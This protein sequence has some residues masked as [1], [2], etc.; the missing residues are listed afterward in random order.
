MTWVVLLVGVLAITPA[1]INF[2]IIAR[3]G[4][5]FYIPVAEL[6]MKGRFH[7]VIWSP[8][9]PFIIP[10]YE[11]LIF[12]VARVSGLDLE[13]SG[14]AISIVS[15]IF[16]TLG[17]YKVTEIIFKDRIVAIISV[18]FFISN[19]ELLW[20]S[21]DCLKESL[22]VCLVLWGNYFIVKGYYSVRGV[23]YTIGGILTLLAGGLVRST[24]MIFLGAWFIMW[25][26][27][28]KDGS[29]KRVLLFFSIITLTFLIYYLNQKLHWGLPIFRRSY[30]PSHLI[31]NE[32]SI[33]DYRI[34]SL[35]MIRQLFAKSYYLIGFFSLIGIYWR[36]R[37]TYTV[38]LVI[39]TLIFFAICVKTTWVFIDRYTIVLVIWLYPIAAYALV[40]SLRSLN[41]PL[42]IIAVIT[43][44]MCPLLWGEKVF[45]PPDPD[46]L[47]RKEAGLWILDRLGPDQ[48]IISN[49]DRLVFYAQG[50]YMP[51]SKYKA[52]NDTKSVLAVDTKYEEGRIIVE[53]AHS[54]GVDPDKQF[55]SISIYLPRS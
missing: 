5:N 19:R 35:N 6:L 50:T 23:K 1:L 41:K 25:I 8:L 48:V 12:I 27:H 30:D 43:M 20:R 47:A 52:G 45:T 14:R 4:A 9:N 46:K 10:L 44:V 38:H 42:K 15:F 54:R 16:G 49:R 37:E 18:L 29:I 36:K 22:L 13:S 2:D 21:V 7:D 26:F 17:I 31:S 40:K 3:D 24:S 28:K 39:V 51:L 11:F 53:E 32:L 34:L 33:Q 55:R